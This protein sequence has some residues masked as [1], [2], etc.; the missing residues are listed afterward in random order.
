MASA[1]LLQETVTMV[2]CRK[3]Q[4]SSAN[5][6]GLSMLLQLDVW[7]DPDLND[8]ISS[9]YHLIPNTTNPPSSNILKVINF[10]NW[11][12]F[13][14]PQRAAVN[15]TARWKK[16]AQEMSRLRSQLQEEMKTT[17][18]AGCFGCI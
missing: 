10:T 14:H 17:C 6:R 1:E 4:D 2:S 5:S 18:H 9:L 12:D 15:P 16:A 11:L 13:N 7:P 8:L 3:R